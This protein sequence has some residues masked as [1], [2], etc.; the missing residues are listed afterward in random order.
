[1]S[2]EK[3]LYTH[4]QVTDANYLRL[5]SLGYPPALIKA[6]VDKPFHFALGLRT[7]ECFFFTG[8]EAIDKDWVHIGEVIPYTSLIELVEDT[9]SEGKE[10]L[11]DTRESPERGLN[12]RVSE[13]AW[14]ADSPV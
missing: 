1:M 4:K 13:I 7:G 6:C 9:G 12:V 2:E 14:A 10:M 11:F 5:H 8:A 3:V